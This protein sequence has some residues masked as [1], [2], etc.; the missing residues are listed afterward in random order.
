[1]PFKIHTFEI[2]KESADG[3]ILKSFDK[4]EERFAENSGEIEKIIMKIYNY[5]VDKYKCKVHVTFKM[6]WALS[7]KNK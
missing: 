3:P 4:T 1:M 5:G 6:E 7:K 2:H